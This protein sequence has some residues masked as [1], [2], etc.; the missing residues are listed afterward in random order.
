MKVGVSV[1]PRT[2]TLIL[3][4]GFSARGRTERSEVANSAIGSWKYM[5]FEQIKFAGSKKSYLVLNKVVAWSIVWCFVL[6]AVYGISKPVDKSFVIVVRVAFVLSLALMLIIANIHCFLSQALEVV[7][8]GVSLKLYRRDIIKPVF[9][10]KVILWGEISDIGWSEDKWGKINI[11]TFI[12]DYSFR[13]V[14]D[15]EGT[16]RAYKALKEANRLGR[17]KRNPTDVF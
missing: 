6:L 7:E 12:K 15:K 4:Y 17:A 5:S 8:K 16:R 9:E 14:G 11:K 2:E 3:R 13:V 10:K 1:R